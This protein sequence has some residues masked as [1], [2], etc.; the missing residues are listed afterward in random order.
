M[1]NLSITHIEVLVEVTEIDQ[2]V[3]GESIRRT[4]CWR[5]SE[6]THM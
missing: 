3:Q 1:I 2:I 4:G 5:G 6:Q